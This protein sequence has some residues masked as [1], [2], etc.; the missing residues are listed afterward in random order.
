MNRERVRLEMVLR[1][2][3]Q[4][5]EDVREAAVACL[6]MAYPDRSAGEVLAMVVSELAENAVKY[7]CWNE[8]GFPVLKVVGYDEHIDVTVEHPTSPDAPLS[9]LFDTLQRI[10]SAPSREQAYVEMMREVATHAETTGGL[11]LARIAHEAACELS[12]RLTPAGTLEVT[13]RSTLFSLPRL[14]P[15]T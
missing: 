13:A 14:R 4:S 2:E 11:G 7:S 9:R 3:W 6:K 8:S 15:S 10:R 5:I 1:Q 12:A